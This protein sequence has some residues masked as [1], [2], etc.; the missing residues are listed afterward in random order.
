MNSFISWIGGKHI[1]AKTII[2]MMP[3]HHAYVEVFG[4]A[5]WVLFKKPPSRVDV[6]N[7]LNGDLVNLFRV[8]RNRLNAFKQRQYFL[9]ASREE[10]TTFQQALKAGKFKDDIDR[11]IA[12]YYCI[13][14]SFGS[15]VYNGWAFGPDRPPTYR[16]GLDHLDAARDRL[17]NVFIDNLSF[18]RLI[19][20]W[21]RGKTLFY[22]DPPYHML[23]D[24]KGRSYYQCTFSVDDH[25]RL[26]DTVR[27]VAGK[28]ILS[29]D[30]HPEVRK[31]Y[32]K[33]FNIVETAP[34][35][36][37]MNNKRNTPARRVGELIITNF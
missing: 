27:G 7:D 3:E 16:N 28:V 15:S 1:L 13:K 6:W 17:K 29:Y 31:L 20:N 9:L 30:D 25:K 36:Y 11:A 8:V 10:Y 23:L 24:L 32:R 4:G 33:G 21:D 12:F 14:N 37:C 35:H 22:C 2:K 34:V 19:H 5:G 18:D 26:R